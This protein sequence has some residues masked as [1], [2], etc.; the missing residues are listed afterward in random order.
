M[1]RSSA[2]TYARRGIRFNAVAPAPTETPPAAPLLRSEVSR[3]AGEAIHPLGRLGRP[4]EIAGVMGYLLGP[5]AGR[6]TGRVWGVDEGG[7]L[8]SRA[9][10]DRRRLLS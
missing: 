9:E 3:S 10:P 4:E 6:V 7:P 2:M 8:P 1:V 5:E